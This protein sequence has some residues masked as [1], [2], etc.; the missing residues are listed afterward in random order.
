MRHSLLEFVSFFFYLDLR[1]VT[2]LCTD[3]D[4]FFFFYSLVTK[5]IFLLYACFFYML[6]LK[7]SSILYSVLHEFHSVEHCLV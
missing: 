3:F 4:F 2:K 6:Q 1:F 7:N 5:H